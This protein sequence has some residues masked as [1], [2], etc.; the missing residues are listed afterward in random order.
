MFELKH[1][2]RSSWTFLVCC[3]GRENL[4]SR[5][6]FFVPSWHEK[7]RKE[8]GVQERGTES[9]K[10]W[11]NKPSMTFL[12]NGIQNGWEWLT[13]CCHKHIWR[14]P[15]GWNSKLIGQ[16]TLV[17]GLNQIPFVES[18]ASHT[19]LTCDRCE[20]Q[21][22]LTSLSNESNPLASNSVREINSC[23]ARVCLF[24]HFSRSFLQHTIPLF[25][26][27]LHNRKNT[28]GK[29]RMHLVSVRD[30]CDH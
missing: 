12:L 22:R 10:P 4:S 13:D 21:G 15:F 30:S 14:A 19:A 26:L 16:T 11:I 28:L 18:L 24:P 2:H 23:N 5:W 3:T 1:D 20:T 29:H 27:W 6:F 25:T 7:S 9:R 8:L 17:L